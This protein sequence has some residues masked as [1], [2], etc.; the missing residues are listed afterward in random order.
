VE[1]TGSLREAAAR[2][3]MSYMKA[4]RLANAMNENFRAPLLEKSRG[5]STGGGTQLTEF[6]RKV[7]TAYHRMTSRADQAAQTDWKAF[8]AFLKK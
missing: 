4:W 7:L 2:L 6:G 1:K 8:S 3:E 5:G